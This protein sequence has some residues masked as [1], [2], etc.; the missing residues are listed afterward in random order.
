VAQL[1]QTVVVAPF[2][3]AGASEALAYLR[4]GLVELLSARLADDSAARSVDAG[5][6]LS[7][8]R[9][10]GLARDVDVPRDTVVRLAERLGAR[11]VVIGS[12]VGTRSR[13]ILSA[14][15]V[16]VPDGAV[17]G[18]A[19]V[20][21]PADSV[22]TLVD[23]LA[24]RLLVQAAGED[25][26]L[27]GQTTE[28]LP[29]LRAFLV[30]QAA[31]RG[32]RFDDALRAYERALQQ[33]STFALAALQLVRTADRLESAEDRSWAL[34]VAWRGQRALSERDRAQLVA[35]AGPRYPEPS[36]AVELL[37]A[38]ERPVQLAP[39]RGSGWYEL[40]ARLFHDGEVAGVRSPRA[41][42][43]FALRRAIELDT[44][45]A[46]ARLL[47]AHLAA[48]V[49]PEPAAGPLPG[50]AALRDSTGQLAPFILWRAAVARGDSAALRR[51]RDAMPRLGRT[52]LRAIAQA[53]QFDGAALTDARRAVGLLR[54][55][56]VRSPDRQDAVEAAHAL[57]LNEGRVDDAARAV[58]ELAELRPGGRAHLRLRVLDALYGGADRTAGEAAARELGRLVETGPGTVP[59]LLRAEREADACVVGQWRL[60]ADDT[61]GVARLVAALEAARPAPAPDRPVVT[62]PGVCAGLLD[63]ALAVT[64]RR[65]DAAARVAHLDSL[66][67]T[68]G[69]A[70]DAIAYA[71]ILVARLHERL[72]DARGAL[73]AVRRRAY[74]VGWPRYQAAALRDEGRYAALAGEVDAARAAYLRFLALRAGAPGTLAGEAREVRAALDQLAEPPPT[75]ERATP[76]PR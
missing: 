51:V 36:P 65:R 2:R 57:A 26:A 6:V 59:T 73:A 54:D 68:A 55:R 5:A 61:A 21:G 7:A 39:E 1:R 60:A 24:A 9:Q 8:W 29:A 33:D 34:A 18:T 41:R 14:T 35:L 62:P 63:A 69:A 27:A 4:D 25:G 72:G 49:P 52:N 32:S 31:F 58:D 17:T 48:G 44:S 22:T 71:P 19:T 43:A 30:G 11:R 37:A 56:A 13:V 42:A 66:A 15:V 3:V 28:S 46:P 75:D 50:P 38:W 16:T 47:L 23:R 70:G 53:A 74:M 76:A 40:G 20:E 12:V 45:D 10:A 67:L 64:L